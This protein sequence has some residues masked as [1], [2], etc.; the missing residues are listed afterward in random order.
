CKDSRGDLVLILDTSGS[1]K[2]KNPENSTGNYNWEL[3]INFSINIVESLNIGI[4]KTRLSVIRFSS[5]AEVIFHLDEYNNEREMIEVIRNLQYLSGSTNTSGA[6]RVLREEVFNQD[7]GDRPDVRNVGIIITDGQSTEDTNLTIPEAIK[8]KDAKIRMFAVGL[9]DDISEEELT[10]IASSPT[11]E[12][13]FES[14]NI[15]EVDTLVSRL[16]WSV[17]HD[18]CDDTRT[19]GNYIP[20]YGT[21]CARYEDGASMVII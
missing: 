16:V 15:S 20:G 3:L 11:N 5:R 1:I 9:T 7:H 13:L 8:T 21:I 18:P 17:C 4:D 19:E 14:A 12:H 6:L 2:D 10:E